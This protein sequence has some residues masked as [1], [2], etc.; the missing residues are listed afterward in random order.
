MKTKILIISALLFVLTSCGG[1]PT[2]PINDNNNSHPQNTQQQNQ[3]WHQQTVVSTK[4]GATSSTKNST[5]ATLTWTG[6][7]SLKVSK[8]NIW[9][10]A[11]L[12]DV[13][14]FKAQYEWFKK[15]STYEDFKNYKQKILNYDLVVFALRLNDKDSYLK[16]YM[17]RLEEMLA[18]WDA[19]VLQRLKSALWGGELSPDEM[20]SK[21][22]DMMSKAFDKLVVW[23]S[24]QQKKDQNMYTGDP[25]EAALTTD[26]ISSIEQFCKLGSP[27]G[28]VVDC[29]NYSYIFR[30]TKDN[31]L[32]DK[33]KWADE[34]RSCL[35]FL[36]YKK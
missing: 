6:S 26:S 9:S 32:C 14:V 28:W 25:L 18:S 2:P 12:E 35:W 29:L 23:L 5:W 13:D 19:Q 3:N 15:I 16:F 24:L 34:K 36:D 1:K 20:K 27:A 11:L 30:A 10:S 21:L 31:K 7:P 33:I 4:T 17:F 22:S 8:E